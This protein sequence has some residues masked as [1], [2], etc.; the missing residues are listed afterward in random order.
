MNGCAI[1][2]THMLTADFEKLSLCFLKMCSLLLLNWSK[3]TLVGFYSAWYWRKF[4]QLAILCSCLVVVTDKKNN[5]FWNENTR[6]KEPIFSFKNGNG[7]YLKY[8]GLWWPWQLKKVTNSNPKTVNI[9]GHFVTCS[10]F[11]S[12]V[13]S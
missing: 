1:N 6:I 8:N 11:F 4:L 7:N 12:A 9:A 13:E 5:K 2:L 3:G 10:F